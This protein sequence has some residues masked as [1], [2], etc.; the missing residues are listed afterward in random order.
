MKDFL[1]KHPEY[2]DNPDMKNLAMDL[3][4]RSDLE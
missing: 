3:I 2:E 4:R 1:E